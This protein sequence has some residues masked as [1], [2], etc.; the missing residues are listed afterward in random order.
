MKLMKDL[1]GCTLAVGGACV[2]AAASAVC[3]VVI[4]SGTR[5]SERAG[6]MIW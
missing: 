2:F 4:V 6:R 1:V 5:L 3:A